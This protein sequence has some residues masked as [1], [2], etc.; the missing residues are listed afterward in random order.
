MPSRPQ[1]YWAVGDSAQLFWTSGCLGSCLL[2]DRPARGSSQDLAH[3]IVV[4]VIPWRPHRKLMPESSGRPVAL[5]LGRVYE[6]DRPP[7]SRGRASALCMLV[8]RSVPSAHR[9]LWPTLPLAPGVSPAYRC[10]GLL[11]RLGRTA[12]AIPG[13]PSTDSQPCHEDLHCTVLTESPV[14]I[15]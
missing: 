3:L 2:P 13:R 15:L 11:T 12:A 8:G 4:L 6:L 1:Y 7:R 5:G 10:G 14:R 9:P